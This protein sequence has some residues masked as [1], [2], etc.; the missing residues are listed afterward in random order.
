MLTGLTPGTSYY[1]SAWGKTGALY[2]AGYVTALAT[3]LAYDT[4]ASTGTIEA[5][6]SN[7]WWNQTPSTTKVSS[8][9]LVSGLVSANATAYA[10]P[11][12]SLWYFLWVLFSVGVGVFIYSKSGNNLPMSLGAQAL[13]FALGAVL[14]LVMLWIMVLFMIIGAGFALWGDRR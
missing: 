11:E 4:A 2:S 13:L 5:P 7:S 12:A 10:I 6:P 3:T 1:F 14:G 8:I 9:P